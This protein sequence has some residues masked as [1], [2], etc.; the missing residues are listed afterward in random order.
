MRYTLWKWPR[1]DRASLY[2]GVLCGNFRLSRKIVSSR[3]YSEPPDLGQGVKGIP[4][5][6]YR[7]RRSQ[8]FTQY[9]CGRLYIGHAHDY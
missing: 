4:G 9:G 3:R 5:Y 1:S 6:R 8:L 2:L 7:I